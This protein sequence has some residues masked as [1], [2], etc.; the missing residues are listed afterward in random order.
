MQRSCREWEEKMHLLKGED[1]RVN[2]GKYEKT[3]SGRMRTDCQGSENWK[4]MS[5]RKEGWRKLA[6]TRAGFGL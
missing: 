6:G 2:L 3:L 1:S 4:L 5:D